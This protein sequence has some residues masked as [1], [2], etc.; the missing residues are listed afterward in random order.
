MIRF[1]RFN[2]AWQMLGNTVFEGNYLSYGEPYIDSFL[3]LLTQW[4]WVMLTAPPVVESKP[5]YLVNQSSGKGLNRLC[6]GDSDTVHRIS[7]KM[8]FVFNVRSWYFDKY[9]TDT[10]PKYRIKPSLDWRLSRIVPHWRNSQCES[11]TITQTIITTEC[12]DPVQGCQ[13]YGPRA[14][15]G[16]LWG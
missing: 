11:K 14:K 12:G 3:N 13:R 15:T 1:W 6:Q 9:R 5:C 10:D 4:M 16:P 7:R 2:T 8:K